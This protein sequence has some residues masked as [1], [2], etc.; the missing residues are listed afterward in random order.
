MSKIIILKGIHAD[1]GQ[2]PH[3]QMSKKFLALEIVKEVTIGMYLER[4][5]P[6]SSEYLWLEWAV[7]ADVLF[8]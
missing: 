4:K 7:K 3:S 1:I 2:L 6:K 5:V 8:L